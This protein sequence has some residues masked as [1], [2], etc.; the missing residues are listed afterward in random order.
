MLDAAGIPILLKAVD[1]LFG[2]GRKILQE[3]R[4]RRKLEQERAAPSPPTVLPP[5]AGADSPPTIRA[6]DSAL[7]QQVSEA[8]W[9]K[10]EAGITHLLSLLEIYARSY[11][12][13]KEQYAKWGSLLVPQ[14]VVFSLEEAEDQF[15]A[16]MEQLQFALGRVYGQKIIAPEL[17]Q[18]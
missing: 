14:A 9:L 11:Y 10:S 17:E 3:R 16:T 4:E 8:A 18:H 12:H 1:F 13:C 6:R 7:K 5:S 2:E 15:A